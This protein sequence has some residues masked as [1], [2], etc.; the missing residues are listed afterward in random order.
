MDNLLYTFSGFVQNAKEEQ[1]VIIESDELTM[2]LNIRMEPT[3]NIAQ[4]DTEDLYV[5]LQLTGVNVHVKLCVQKKIKELA[6]AHDNYGVTGEGVKLDA[7]EEHQEMSL[8]QGGDPIKEEPVEREEQTDS[9]PVDKPT[10]S[11]SFVIQTAN[12]GGVIGDQLKKESINPAITSQTCRKSGRTRTRTK[13]YVHTNNLPKAD[14]PK[15]YTSP[16]KTKP[17]KKPSRY[18]CNICGLPCFNYSRLR[19]HLK[20]HTGEKTHTCHICQKSFARKTNLHRHFHR[21]SSETNVICSVCGKRFKTWD[22]LQTHSYVHQNEKRFKCD[23]CSKTFTH[24]ATL[25]T[26]VRT[27]TGE[28]PYLC[29]VCGNAYG[30]RANMHTHMMT[31]TGEKR[32]KCDVCSKRFVTSSLLR[33]HAVVHTGERNYPCDKCEQKF[34]TNSGLAIH[35]RIHVDERPHKCTVCDQSFKVPEALK[36]HVKSHTGEKPYTC[37]KCGKAFTRSDY[38]KKHCK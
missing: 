22:Y 30:N 19:I 18:S 24:S 33:K 14:S 35:K 32:Y 1:D 20:V 21:H 11:T 34:G 15:P 8:H 16:S 17:K 2:T 27:H 10:L 28:K 37:N 13:K 6:L 31:H 29:S 26:H 25:K 23:Y 36:R 12:E 38:A 5:V 4:L 7:N 9:M 3:E